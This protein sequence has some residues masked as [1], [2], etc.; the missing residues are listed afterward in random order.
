MAARHVRW[1]AAVAA[2]AF[3]LGTGAALHVSAQSSARPQPTQNVDPLAP[4]PMPPELVGTNL[5]AQSAEEAAAK[6]AGCI[7]CHQNVRDPHFK[8][9]VRLGCT[10][11]H[12]GRA[13]C[14][15]KFQAHVAP[16]YPEFWRTAANPVR[17]YAL[18]NHESPEFVRF[19]N[20]GDFRIAHIS[21]GTANCS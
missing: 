1:A 12:G 2:V 17:S 4:F 18:L 3:T 20:P 19:V 14:T 11:C 13:D 8:D 5:L 21:C 10:D 15:D 16:R 9:T 6:S 7:A